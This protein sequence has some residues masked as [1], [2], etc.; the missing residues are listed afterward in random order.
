MS[1]AKVSEITSSSKKGFEDAIQKGIT[2]FAKTVDQVQGAWVSEQKV[3]VSG[4]KISEYRV[5]L[6]VTFV[7]TD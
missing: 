4:G 6:R 7:L 1:V 2:R 5:T 3:T